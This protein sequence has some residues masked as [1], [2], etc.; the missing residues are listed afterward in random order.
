MKQKKLKLLT[1]FLMLALFCMILPGAGCN[2]D[3]EYSNLVEG[4][5]VGSFVCDA[6]GTDGQ[7]TGN[8]TERGYCILLEGNKNSDSHR[9]MDFYTFDLPPG[10]FGFPEEIML[11]GSNGN[12]CGPWFFPDS[13]KNEYKISFTYRELNKKE[14]IKFTCG[15]CMAMESMFPWDDYNEASLKKI[16]NH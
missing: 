9:P 3:D 2:D 4:Y 8:N 7:A 1:V 5:I 11:P 16:V 14:R 13:L 15:S 6:V 10:L 12:N